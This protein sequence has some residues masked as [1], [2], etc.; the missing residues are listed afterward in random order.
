[1]RL[2]VGVCDDLCAFN[3]IRTGVGGGGGGG[4][5]KLHSLISP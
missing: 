1:M 5:L 2:Y 4:V 3:T